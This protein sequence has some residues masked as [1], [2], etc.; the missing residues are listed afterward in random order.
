[1]LSKTI[2]TF[3]R[4]DAAPAGRFAS[5]VASRLIVS[6]EGLNNLRQ[7]YQTG[8][9]SRRCRGRSATGSRC[10]RRQPSSAAPMR[11]ISSPD[12]MGTTTDRT[13]RTSTPTTTTRWFVGLGARVRFSHAGYIVGEYTP[14]IC[15]LRS[16]R[17]RVGRRDRETH[18]R[19]HA[20]AE[21]HQLV[22]D[23]TRTD[24]RGEAARTTS[25]SDSTSRGSSELLFKGEMHDETIRSGW[26]AL[27]S[28]PVMRQQPVAPSPGTPLPTTIDVHGRAAA[29]ERS[30]AD[31]QRGDQRARLGARS[32]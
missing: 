24:S 14:R 1:M 26:S 27:C 31:H 20:A 8:V 22:R 32:P 29:R 4:W 9:G 3:G 11:S 2:Q 13:R 21:L 30:A 12:T 18:R 16:E 17:G 5:R 25:I 23:D 15:R 28:S 10:T 6:Y 19:P 7:Q